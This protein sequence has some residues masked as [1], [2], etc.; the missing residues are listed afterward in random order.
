MFQNTAK[1]RK[2]KLKGKV[3]LCSSMLLGKSR[4]RQRKVKDIGENIFN[5]SGMYCIEFGTSDRHTE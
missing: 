5:E 4:K 2:V 3:S 1:N